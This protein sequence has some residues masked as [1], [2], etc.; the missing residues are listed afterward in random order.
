MDSS[1]FPPFTTFT[2]NAISKLRMYDLLDKP[3]QNR[4][5]QFYGGLRLF[6]RF[7]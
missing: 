2:Y 7:Q 6:D 4:R 5:R 3:F 1:T